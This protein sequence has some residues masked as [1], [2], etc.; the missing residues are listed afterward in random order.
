MHY[1]MLIPEFM[2]LACHRYCVFYSII[3]VLMEN[4]LK[5][6]IELAKF[7]LTILKDSP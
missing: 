3:F 4:S 1:K 7:L 5:F 2:N 6:A